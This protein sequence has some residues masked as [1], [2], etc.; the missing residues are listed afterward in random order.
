MSLEERVNLLEKVVQDQNLLI[1]QLKLEIRAIKVSQP[2]PKKSLDEFPHGIIQLIMEYVPQ[3]VQIVKL[4]N[5]CK[6][7][8]MHVRKQEIHVL[9]PNTFK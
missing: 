5:T 3:T 4:S 1:N 7:L 9:A 6:Q 8:K 2:S